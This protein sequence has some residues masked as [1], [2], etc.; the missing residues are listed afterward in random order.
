MQ[1]NVF[2]PHDNIR[3]PCRLASDLLLRK[4]S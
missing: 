1:K 4:V 3:L 2:F